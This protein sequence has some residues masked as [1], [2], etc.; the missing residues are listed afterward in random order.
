MVPQNEGKEKSI[1]WGHQR[2]GILGALCQ[3][4]HWRHGSRIV[5]YQDEVSHG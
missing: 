2:E 5:F 4:L 1:L 3:R